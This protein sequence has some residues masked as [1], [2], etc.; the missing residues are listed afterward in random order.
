MRPNE[1]EIENAPALVVKSLST[2]YGGIEVLHEISLE[3]APGEVVAVLGVNGA[4]KSTLLNS[5]AG[6]VEI[7][8]GKVELFG[9]DVT[10]LRAHDL[11]KLGVVLVPERRELFPPLSVDENLKAALIRLKIRSRAEVS[12]R[13]E[14]V[15]ESFPVLADRRSQFAGTLSGGEQQM[16]AIGRGL[17]VQPRIILLDEPSLGLNPIVMDQIYDR[18]AAMANSNGPT[19]IV[20]EQHVERALNL[21]S[22]GYILD[23]GKVVAQGSSADL[24]NDSV[25][26]VYLGE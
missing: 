12:A 17:M 2:G 1:I 18:L 15:Y 23:L 10:K 8:S 11:V 20:V 22:R 21:A 16:L 19:M 14:S 5:L 25:K 7:R 3:V 4:G 13:I 9:R 6:L 26:N 24:R